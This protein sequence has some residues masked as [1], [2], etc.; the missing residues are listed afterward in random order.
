MI[1]F[2]SWTWGFTRPKFWM[3]YSTARLGDIDRDP[4]TENCY[5]QGQGRYGHGGFW[6]FDRHQETGYGE[7]RQKI[8]STNCLFSSIHVL[9]EPIGAGMVTLVADCFLS[10]L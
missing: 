4:G 3:P 5:H 9:I 2:R 8:E 6:P 7:C 10:T 1:G